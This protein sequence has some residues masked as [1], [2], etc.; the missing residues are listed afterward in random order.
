MTST[1][2]ASEGIISAYLK[3]VAR[4]DASVVERFFH[5][6]IEYVVNGV[7]PP[8]Q[9]GDLPP[10][11]VECSTALPWLGLYR[12]RDA[13]RGFLEHM[14]RNLEITAFGPLEVIAQGNKGAAF[15]RFRLEAL[16][17]R[18]SA[19][20]SFAVNF[21]LR[22][23]LIAKYHFVENTLDVANAFHVDGTWTFVTDGAER[24]VPALSVRTFTSSEPGAWANSYLIAG[25]TDAILYDVPMLKSDAAELARMIEHSG[26]TLTAVVISHAH[27]DHF[28]SLE[29]IRE[30][31]PAARF[32]S[33]E[34]VV[35]DI[36]ADGPWM[37]S[38]VRQKFGDD[39]AQNV[40]IPEILESRQLKIE[41][42][43]LD[44]VEFAQGECKNLAALHAPALRALFC[45]DLLY[46]NA[47]AYLQERHLESWLDRLNELE[48]YV[49]GSVSILYPGHGAAS[50]FELINKTR[51]YLRD[52][53][54]AVGLGDAAA[55]QRQM[56]SKYPN[57][58]AAQFLTVFSI[59]AYFT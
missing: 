49:G 3:A 7:A 25:K 1:L 31:F 54:D 23:G 12:G 20:I 53:R 57:Y 5:R 52:F 19:D 14:H 55:A 51:T 8:D 26:K 58:H 44:I 46:N 6:E 38:A 18:R 56:L 50:G 32:L 42:E 35:E 34:K 13:V 9:L 47:H 21:E 29:L 24:S 30:R 10:I 15:G 36:T 59:P 39:A 33:T 28:L 37:L 45:A 4:K 27:P 16:T 43:R 41:N 17:T 40:V 11:S 22:D 2:D 48:S